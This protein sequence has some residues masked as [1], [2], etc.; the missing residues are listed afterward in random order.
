MNSIQLTFCRHP[1]YYGRL[2]L[3]KTEVELELLTDVGILLMIEKG[4]KGE[5]FCTIH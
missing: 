2:V 5:M 4:F 1:N 3:K